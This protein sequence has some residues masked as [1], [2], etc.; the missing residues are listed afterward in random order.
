M[1]PIGTGF[2]AN[3]IAC[4]FGTEDWQQQLSSKRQETNFSFGV[5]L[6]IVVNVLLFWVIAFVFSFVVNSI[7]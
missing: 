1:T 3:L 7:H 5:Q 6:L 4:I 2:S